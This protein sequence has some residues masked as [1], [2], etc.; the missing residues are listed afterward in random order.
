[1]A[2]YSLKCKEGYYCNE[3]STTATPPDGVMG[4]RCPVGKYCLEGTSTP[5]DCPKGTFSNARGM[6]SSSRIKLRA[7][8]LVYSFSLI[9]S[10]QKIGEV[11]EYLRG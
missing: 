11:M 9:G 3:G 5:D 10:D 1:M 4:G 7:V 6:F 8:L 2:T